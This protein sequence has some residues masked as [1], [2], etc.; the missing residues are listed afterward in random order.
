MPDD[1]GAGGGGTTIEMT[2][3][4]GETTS[5]VELKKVMSVFGEVDVCHMGLRGSDKPFVRF[6]TSNAAEAA[7]TA[8]KN[9]KVFLEDGVSMLAGDLKQGPRSRG[10]GPGARRRDETEDMSSRNLIQS[11]KRHKSRSRSSRSR[12][13]SRSK[14]KKRKRGKEKEKERQ[15]EKDKDKDKKS[16]SRSRDRRGHKRSR[17]ASRSR[18]RKGHEEKQKKETKR[19]TAKEDKKEEKEDKKEKK[20]DKKEEKAEKKLPK[21]EEPDPPKADGSGGAPA[22]SGNSPSSAAVLDDDDPLAVAEGSTGGAQEAATG[23][24]PKP[25][26][27]VGEGGRGGF[28][29]PIFGRGKA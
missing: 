19:K 9:G 21:E 6:R 8:L 16:R 22:T 18:R 26:V 20:E 27:P 12:S 24:K 25:I 11:K 10:G 14:S 5:R 4:I 7:L 1:D 13:R 15:K 28:T 17:S 2:F 29:N 23:W 3:G